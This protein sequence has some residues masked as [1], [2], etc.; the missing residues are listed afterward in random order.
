MLEFYTYEW[1]YI[2]IHITT[3]K[4]ILHTKCTTTNNPSSNDQDILAF[5]NVTRRRRGF[6]GGRS[7]NAPIWF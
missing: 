4:N 5:Q 6:C 1:V 2:Y 7:A 3:G